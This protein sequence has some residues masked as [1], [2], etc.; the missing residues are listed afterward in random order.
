L[1]DVVGDGEAEP[2]AP[3]FDAADQ[4]PS[5]IVSDATPVGDGSV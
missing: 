3:G 4:Q 5:I 2:A 1:P